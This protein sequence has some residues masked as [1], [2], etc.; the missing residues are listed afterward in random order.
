MLLLHISDIHF[1]SPACLHPEQDPDRPYRTLMVQD[2]RNRLRRLGAAHAILV[3][4]DIA[5]KGAPDEYEIAM[6]WIE[7]LSSAACCPLERIF[8]IPGNHDVDRATI[9]NSPAVQ[10]AQAAI[11]R[12]DDDEREHEFQ[13]QI[14][15]IHTGRVL[16]LPL[17][18]Y[19][20]FARS[21]N[22]HIHLP[23]RLFWRHNLELEQGVVLRLHGLTSTLISGARGQDDVRTVAHTTSELLTVV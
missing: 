7:E 21:F 4:G 13:T 17:T 23:N 5:F 12:A 19:N 20:N 14:R 18:A 6:A 15:D 11:M 16:C 3:G 1:R 10:N 2:V 22:C 9:S 8:V